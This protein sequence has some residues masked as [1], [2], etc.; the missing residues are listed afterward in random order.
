V[1]FKIISS[2]SLSDLIKPS[3]PLKLWPSSGIALIEIGIPVKYFPVH[4]PL[5][6][7]GIIVLT[8]IFPFPFFSTFN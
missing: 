8:F 6:N 1:P 3:H 4:L 2:T 5:L 7:S